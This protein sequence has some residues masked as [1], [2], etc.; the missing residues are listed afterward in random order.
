MSLLRKETLLSILLSKSEGYKEI[1]A[2]TQNIL[3]HVRQA[4]DKVHDAVGR[5]GS[6]PCFGC[7]SNAKKAYFNLVGKVTNLIKSEKNYTAEKFEKLKIAVSRMRK[8][9]ALVLSAQYK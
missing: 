4:S 8:G 6:S 3:E 7:K 2:M 9:F 1:A 5:I